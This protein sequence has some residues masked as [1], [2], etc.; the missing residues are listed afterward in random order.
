MSG[1]KD[2]QLNEIA[3]EKIF[4]DI[5]DFVFI[6]LEHMKTDLLL[7]NKKLKNKEEEIRTHL[8]EIGRAHV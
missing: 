7:Q 1:F 2:Q 6:S 8:L 3:K 4:E 5:I